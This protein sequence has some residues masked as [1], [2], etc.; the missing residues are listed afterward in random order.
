MK[1]HELSLT[2]RAVFPSAPD[3]TFAAI[4]RE[5]ILPEVLTGYGPLPAVVGTSD[6]TGPWNHPGSARLVHLADG[7]TV[8]EQVTHYDRPGHFAYRIWEF[9]NPIVGRLASGGRGEWRFRPLS[10]GT[11][12][13]WTYTFTARSAA[14]AIPLSAIVGIFFRGYMNVCLKNY[15]RLLRTPADDQ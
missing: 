9:G 4:V 2:K 15:T 12:V 14:A 7:T 6:R 3:K 10:A 5:D 13:L 8:R 11:E 1:A